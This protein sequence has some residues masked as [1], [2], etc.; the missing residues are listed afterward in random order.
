MAPTIPEEK[1]DEIK[2]ASDIVAVVGETVLL[3]KAGRNY[4]GLCPFHA[5][6]TPSFT[7]SPDKQMFYCFGCG[8]GGSVFSFLMKQQGLTFPEAVKVLAER[9]GIALP[10]QRQSAEQN[11]RWQERDAILE[12]NELAMGVYRKTLP[13]DP[14]AQEARD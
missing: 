8:E 12:L 11:R 9:A 14:R 4:Q 5:E 1:I 3:K 2:D 7:V 10:A 13:H 6:K